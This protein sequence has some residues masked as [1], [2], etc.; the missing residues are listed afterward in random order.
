MYNLFLDDLRNTDERTI[1]SLSIYDEDGNKCKRDYHLNSIWSLV[2]SYREFVDHVKKH[3]SP[4]VVSFDHDLGEAHM[5]M[6]HTGIW[7]D[8]GLQAY[9]HPMNNAATGYD[10]LGFLLSFC[11]EK[12]I[13]IPTIYIHTMNPWGREN[14]LALIK[15]FKKE[16]PE[17]V[18]KN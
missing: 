4:N 14:M 15:E 8:F 6:Y 3:G 7:R 1:Q 10:C 9:R 16:Y 17:C 18:K 11:V 5:Q 13:Q 2:K 12:S